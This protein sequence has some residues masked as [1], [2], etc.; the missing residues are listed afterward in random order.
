MK[1]FF[2]ILVFCIRSIGHAMDL[3]NRNDHEHHQYKILV[4]QGIKDD[5][6]AYINEEDDEDEPPI[7]IKRSP[8][9][10]ASCTQQ[11]LIQRAV[12]DDK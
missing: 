7:N 10:L 11:Q 6:T 9:G 5:L 4:S 12:K 3:S 2:V 8:I 1:W